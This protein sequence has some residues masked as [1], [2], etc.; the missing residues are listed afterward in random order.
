[1]AFDPKSILIDMFALMLI[2]NI[3]EYIGSFYLKFEVSGNEEGHEIINGD[4][5]LKFDF[6]VFQNM[7]SY[8]WNRVFQFFWLIILTFDFGVKAIDGVD[9]VDNRLL[10]GYQPTLDVI[11]FF[12]SSTDKGFGVSSLADIW[13]GGFP[14]SMGILYFILRVK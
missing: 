6:T 8:I 3:D 11:M 9:L 7:L 13:I 10:Y 1:M 2:N 14:I 5:F 12:D 4:D